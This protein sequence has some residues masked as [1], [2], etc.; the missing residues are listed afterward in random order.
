MNISIGNML[1]GSDSSFKDKF[2]LS[3]GFIL[4]SIS[5]IILIIE[6]VI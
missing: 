4:N 6:D 3:W 1:N 2:K 5:L